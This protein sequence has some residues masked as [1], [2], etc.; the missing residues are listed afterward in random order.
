VAFNIILSVSSTGLFSSYITC[1]GCV[2]VKRIRGKQFPPSKFSLGVWGWAV[3]ILA[4]CFL[5][6]AYIF[7]FF[8]AVPH[9]DAASMNWAV[10]LHP[11][12]VRLVLTMFR[13]LSTELQYYSALHITSSRPV[14]STMDRCTMFDG[15]QNRKWKDLNDRC[16]SAV[17]SIL[18]REKDECKEFE[19]GR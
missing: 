7:L 12:L 1:V 17:R 13:F 11:Q 6:V 8:P 14:K 18:C 10:L 16:R 4:L 19:T 5:F 2:L 9:P 15:R 3:N